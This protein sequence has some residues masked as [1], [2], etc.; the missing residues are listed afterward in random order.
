MVEIVGTFLRAE[1]WDE[2][3]N[4]SSEPRNSS[5]GDL[6]QELLKFAVGQLNR[7]QVRRVLWKVANGRSHF[8]NRLPNAGTQVDSAVIH[9]D[10]VTAPER[11][12]Q[13]LL[14]ICEEHLS[15]HRALDYHRRGHLIVPQA[16]HEGDCLP[17][18]KRNSADHPNATRSPSSQP[19]QVRADR[20]L[21]DKHQP[22]GIKHALLS[23]P[24][25]ARSRHIC[26]LPFGSLQAFFKRDVAAIE[27]APKRA[28]AGSNPPFAQLCDDLYQ[29]QI[30]L[31]FNQ[32]Q[33]L[34][35]KLFERRSAAAA[36]L[37][38]GAPYVAPA[39]CP[40]YRRAHAYLETFGC[41]VARRS[42]LHRFDNAFPQ[43][44]RIG[45]RHRQ[46]P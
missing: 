45:L 34:A 38:R 31:F 19:Y 8:L 43:V 44:T 9:H 23:Y 32:G 12:Y 6:A 24:T 21:I 22:S 20:S 28:A 14:D 11:A 13:A 39:L 42:R 30:L 3:A 15:G 26:S 40:L 27:K 36:R 29:S 33:D 37:R 5:R 35:G 10:D 7:I 25:S 17:C 2:R 1:L 18:S 4:S 16:G 46:P 41:L